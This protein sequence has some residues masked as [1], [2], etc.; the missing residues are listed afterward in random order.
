LATS[1]SSRWTRTT[2]GS[3]PRS[4]SGR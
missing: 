1:T 3:T 2:S 4:S